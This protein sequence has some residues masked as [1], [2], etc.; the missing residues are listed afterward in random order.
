MILVFADCVKLQVPPDKLDTHHTDIAA[1][2]RFL[3]ILKRSHERGDNTAVSQHKRIYIVRQQITISRWN[4]CAVQIVVSGIGDSVGGRVQKLR[5]IAVQDQPFRLTGCCCERHRFACNFGHIADCVPSDFTLRDSECCRAQCFDFCPQRVKV[6]RRL[7][8]KC[9][10]EGR[11]LPRVVLHSICCFIES[12]DNIPFLC[13][14]H[15]FFN[16][17]LSVTSRT[18]LSYCRMAQFY[19]I[20]QY[21]QSVI[22]GLPESARLFTLTG[23]S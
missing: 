23:L 10:S 2:R 16:A 11:K 8:S 18:A 20:R 17:F 14:A 3:Q 5:G 6:C 9:D 13:Y 15:V 21:S 19:A 12:H 1:S 7:L 4:F 22:H